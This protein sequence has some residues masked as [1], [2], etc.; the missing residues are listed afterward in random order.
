MNGIIIVSINFVGLSYSPHG[1]AR[2]AY[3]TPDTLFSYLPVASLTA[4]GSTQTHKTAKNIWKY[5]IVTFMLCHTIF[6][7][8]CLCKPTV[9]V[10]T[11]L[12]GFHEYWPSHHSKTVDN[13]TKEKTSLQY[14]ETVTVSR[15]R[16]HF[17]QNLKYKFCIST[18]S[19]KCNQSPVPSWTVLVR[20]Y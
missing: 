12:Y 15:K 9:V 10:H 3:V 14:A 1:F 5:E 20:D 17:M 8:W 19:Q 16:G 6:F 7:L 13:Y 11:F 2:Y 18:L 4:Q